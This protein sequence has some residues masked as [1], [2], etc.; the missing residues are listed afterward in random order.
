MKSLGFSLQASRPPVSLCLDLAARLCSRREPTFIKVSLRGAWMRSCHSQCL[1]SRR[2]SCLQIMADP[3]DDQQM[4]VEQAAQALAA[5]DGQLPRGPS[6][7]SHRN[8]P[9]WASAKQGPGN[10]A[11]AHVQARVGAAESLYLWW[12][13]R[14]GGS[15]RLNKRAQQ[16]GGRSHVGAPAVTPHV[17][18]CTAPRGSGGTASACRICGRALSWRNERPESPPRMRCMHRDGGMLMARFGLASLRLADAGE[19]DLN[20]QCTQKDSA[21]AGH[22]MSLQSA[23]KNSCCCT[24]QVSERPYALR[25]KSMS[26]RQAGSMLPSAWGSDFTPHAVMHVQAIK[27]VHCLG[28]L[29]F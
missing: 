14:A 10:H 17:L 2:Q 12:C 27:L 19:E 1:L 6:C 18:G 21:H 26:L 11:H 29:D 22:P 15:H 3:H 20:E 9:Q 24:T 4:I 5:P 8:E 16:G 13:D 25:H 7:S 23:D 28:L